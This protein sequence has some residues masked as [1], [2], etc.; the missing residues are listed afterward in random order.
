[1]TIKELQ[2]QA[3]KIEERMVDSC[4]PYIV[5][6]I[7]FSVKH[8]ME[9][10]TGEDLENLIEHGKI[11]LNMKMNFIEEEVANSYLLKDVPDVYLPKELRKYDNRQMVIVFEKVTREIFEDAKVECIISFEAWGGQASVTLNLIRK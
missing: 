1:M 9:N 5:R 3:E 8:K 10:L 4:R 7:K 6:P 11:K 2:Q